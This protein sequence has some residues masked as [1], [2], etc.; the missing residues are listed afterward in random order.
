MKK[1]RKMNS[2]S[3]KKTYSPSGFNLKKFAIV[4]S[5]LF[6]VFYGLFN[7][8]KLIIG[9]RI[10]ILEPKTSEVETDSSTITIRGR[11]ENAAFLNLNERPIFTDTNGL[12]EE[13]LLLS[14]G[15]NT[16][17]IRARDRFKKE[18][19]KT[20][21]VYYKPKASEPTSD[22]VSRTNTNLIIE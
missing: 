3:L 16:I 22:S 10:E 4:T 20:V 14:E 17:E 12:F 21:M 19:E 2:D 9:P 8:R 5:V 6:L 18:T 1:I 13:K 15:F 11:A 7:A